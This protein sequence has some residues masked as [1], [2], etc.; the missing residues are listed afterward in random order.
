[1]KVTLSCLITKKQ[2]STVIMLITLSLTSYLFHLFGWIY[3]SSLPVNMFVYLN[4]NVTAPVLVK[5]SE[6]TQLQNLSIEILK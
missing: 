2:Y 4:V 5:Q 6:N 1:M 3:K